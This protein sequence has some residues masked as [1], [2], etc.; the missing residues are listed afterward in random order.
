MSKGSKSLNIMVRMKK[1]LKNKLDINT[2]KEVLPQIE[3][4]I[5]AAITEVMSMIPKAKQMLGDKNSFIKKKLDAL[6]KKMY[7]S[8]YSF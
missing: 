1:L 5:P 2:L 6:E 7:R 3:E 8:L 4:S